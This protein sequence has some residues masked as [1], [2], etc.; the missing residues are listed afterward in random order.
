MDVVIVS[1]EVYEAEEGQG[2]RTAIRGAGGIAG[3][4]AGGWLGTKGGAAVG[5]AIGAWFGGAGAVPGAII[6]GIIGGIGG[7]IGGGIFGRWG[8]ESAYDFVEELFTPNID[9]QMDEIDA[10]ED[11]YIRSAQ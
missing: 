3:A 9:A 2:L 7:A 11:A 5:G 4:A 8:A 10:A 1:W 6:G